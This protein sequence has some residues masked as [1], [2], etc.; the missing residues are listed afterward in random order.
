M[1]PVLVACI[2]ACAFAA[3]QP[4]LAATSLSQLSGIS[5]S[6]ESVAALAPAFAASET[7]YTQSVPFA[8]SEV[9]FT[10]TAAQPSNV[11]LW[12]T[13]NAGPEFQLTSGVATAPL[14]L[15]SSTS[16]NELLIVIVSAE[17]NATYIV[18]ILRSLIQ[19]TNAN[20]IGLEWRTANGD[21]P[22]AMDQLISAMAPANFSSQVFEYAVTLASAVSTLR[23]SPTIDALATLAYTTNEIAIADGTVEAQSAPRSL[24]TGES[25]DQLSVAD[26]KRLRLN[27]VVTAE[28]GTTTRT[29]RFTMTRLDDAQ[30]TGPQ[31]LEGGSSG[32]GSHATSSSTG[33]HLAAATE[34]FSRPVMIG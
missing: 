5:T 9:T 3:I 28:D 13:W 20:L 14:P 15:L 34:Q 22:A 21:V 6:L 11:A 16:F 27:A 4:I 19:S 18:D 17:P 24:R 31:G 1:R 7:S 30:A 25:S 10:V 8:S 33:D 2:C 12:A 32:L 29:Y 23:F 26:T